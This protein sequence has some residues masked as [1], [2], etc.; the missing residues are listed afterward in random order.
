MTCLAGG[1]GYAAASS[2]IQSRFARPGPE[3]L[4]RLMARFAQAH[5]VLANTGL[6]SAGLI[7]R[8]DA[9]PTVNCLVFSTP[10]PQRRAF[11]R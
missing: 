7:N 10:S 5:V 1:R 3:L 9:D 8:F 4:R 6:N 2:A 11:F